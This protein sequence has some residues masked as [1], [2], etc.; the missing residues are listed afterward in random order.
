[1]LNTVWSDSSHGCSI[2]HRAVCNTRMDYVMVASRQRAV[3]RPSAKIRR[4]CVVAAPSPARRCRVKACHEMRSTWRAD[5]K[6]VAVCRTELGAFQLF[7]YLLLPFFFSSSSC[8]QFVSSSHAQLVIHAA[9]RAL[10]PK[11]PGAQI[12]RFGNR[13]KLSASAGRPT[14]LKLRRHTPRN[15]QSCTF[16]LQL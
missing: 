6:G 12:P 9:T 10:R 5:K 1:M 7:F 13:N 14:W 15:L 4:H 2:Q 11:C 16:L 3:R 8:S